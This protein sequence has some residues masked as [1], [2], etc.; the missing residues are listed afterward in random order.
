MPGGCVLAPDGSGGTF[1]AFYFGPYPPALVA[2]HLTSD[3][4]PAPGWTESGYELATGVASFGI[5]RSDAG[6]IVA[7][8]EGRPDAPGIYAQRLVPDGPVAVQLSLVG[9]T[10]EPGNVSLHWYATG[11][12]MLAATVERRA[13]DTDWNALGTVSADGAG[14]LRYEDGSMGAGRFGY[15]VTWTEDGTARHAGEVWVDV[16][17]AWRLALSAP[18]PNPGSGPASF[19]VTLADRAPAS[20]ELLD[21]QGRRVAHRDLGAFDA[22]S[23]VVRFEEA[24]ALAPGVYLARLTQGVETR[25]VRV[26][27]IR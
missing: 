5:V 15:R 24:A 19:A 25:T 3:G 21:L 23:H 7:W 2:Q 4:S 10:A 22:G 20:I 26:I 11:A 1:I 12:A 18:R 14:H 6:A 17:D 16:P 8:I 9:A 27:R 13:D